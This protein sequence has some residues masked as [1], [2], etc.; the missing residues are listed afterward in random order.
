LEPLLVPKRVFV[1]VVDGWET[2]LTSGEQCRGIRLAV[3][4]REEVALISRAAKAPPVV[5]LPKAAVVAA[6]DGWRLRSP[7]RSAGS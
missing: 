4:N 2:F 3:V 6:L 7:R 5:A 1:D